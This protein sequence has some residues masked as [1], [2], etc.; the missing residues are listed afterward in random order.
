MFMSRSSERMSADAFTRASVEDY[1]RAVADE[2]TRIELA[3]AE[4]RRRR[5][6]AHE[7]LD[8]LDTVGNVPAGWQATESPATPVGTGD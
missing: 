2:R 6:A 3:I 7:V 4:A 8:R 1:L 5:D